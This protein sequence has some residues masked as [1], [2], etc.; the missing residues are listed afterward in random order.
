MQKIRSF[1]HFYALGRLH[2]IPR[3]CVLQW[4]LEKQF[5]TR[6]TDRRRDWGVVTQGRVPCSFHAA[7]LGEVND[8]Q[9]ATI[10]RRRRSASP[11]PCS[12]EPSH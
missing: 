7:L 8:A 9:R 5:G 12:T 3:C 11:D 4:C 6:P 10:E 1:V 2:G